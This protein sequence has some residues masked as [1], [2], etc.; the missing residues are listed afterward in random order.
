MKEPQV[1]VGKDRDIRFNKAAW[2][3]LGK[4]A[5]VCVIIG[6]DHAYVSFEPTVVKTE[7]WAM[8]GRT[9]HRIGAPAL[10]RELFEHGWEPGKYRMRMGEKGWT[11]HR[12]LQ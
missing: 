10:I 4:P 1:V 8:C 9:D 12:Y 11:V 7:G 6:K 5:R 2:E 3:A